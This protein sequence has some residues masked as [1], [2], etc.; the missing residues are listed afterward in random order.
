L[1]SFLTPV[2]RSIFKN[3]EDFTAFIWNMSGCAIIIRYVVATMLSHP[4]SAPWENC[5]E[6]LN[7]LL[8]VAA[9]AVAT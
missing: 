2:Q 1:L 6:V 7:I 4:L 8:Q 3:D 9:I 5:M